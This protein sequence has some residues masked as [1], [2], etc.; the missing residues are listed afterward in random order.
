MPIKAIIFD[1]DGTLVDS[2]RV[3]NAVLIE[4][5]A[6]LGLRLT[7]DTA[8][9]HFAGRKMADTLRLIEQ[10]LGAP[11]PDSFLPAVRARM[12][13]AFEEQLKAMPGVHELLNSLSIPICV[14]SNGPQEKMQV[15]LRVTG[16]LKYFPGRIF[17]AYDC[18]SWKPEPGLF[19]HAAKTLNVAPGSCAVVEDSPLGIRAAM[20]AGM[21][22][23]G[24]APEGAGVSLRT[25]GATVFHHMD[26]LG[27][28]LEA[29]DDDQKRSAVAPGT[30]RTAL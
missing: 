4:C 21:T 27:G 5:V 22:A 6:E 24:Y 1:C 9:E 18:G 12:A 8:L 14:A 2:E 19:L 13:D 25:E 15:S 11:V 28:L 26:A 17:S 30:V 3:G 23:F 16:L 7:L 29:L 10:W 20:A